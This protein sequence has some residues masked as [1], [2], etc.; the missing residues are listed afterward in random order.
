MKTVV[1]KKRMK[2]N[3]NAIHRMFTRTQGK[4]D[5]FPGKRGWAPVPQ[6]LATLKY[7]LIGDMEIEH[8]CDSNIT[9]NH[10]YSSKLTYT[11]TYVKNI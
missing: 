11:Y 1:C 6:G 8:H 9:T 7:T 3:G 4:E 10:V 5:S 2:R